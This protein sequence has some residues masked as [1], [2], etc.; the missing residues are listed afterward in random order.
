MRS[1]TIPRDEFSQVLVEKLDQAGVRLVAAL[2]DD[3]VNP[4][5][6]GVEEHA[7]M[8]LIRV[9]REPEIVA[10]CAGSFFAGVPAVGVMGSTGLLACISEIVTLN[11][12]HQI[13]L[14]L[15]VSLRGTVADQQIFQEVQGRV[16]RPVTGSLGLAELL[17]DTRESIEQVPA[18]LEHSRIQKRPTVCWLDKGLLS[19]RGAH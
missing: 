11:L 6:R 16:M 4:V 10:I 8:R 5:V 14:L 3:W 2:P 18:A 13:P 12:R 1:T 9:A 15:L 17:L 19:G 7:D